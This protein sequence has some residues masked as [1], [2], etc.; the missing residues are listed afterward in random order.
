M[1]G[2]RFALVSLSACAFFLSFSA[3][4]QTSIYGGVDAT[5]YAYSSGNSGT[6][7]YDPGTGKYTADK[8][9]VGFDGGATY[10]FPSRSR[11]KA[12]IDGRGTYSPGARGGAAG[13]GALRIAFVPQ[14]NPWSPYFQIGGGVL[15]TTV[16]SNTIPNPRI[17]IN[18][19]AAVFDFGVDIRV[20]SRFAVRAIELDGMAGSNVLLSSFGAGVVYT[21]HHQ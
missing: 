10:L 7:S 2:C 5:Q 6:G 18:S 3:K 4:A 19:G 9:G 13:F 16:V 15:S 20:N 12:G 1:S 8:V 11:L 17:R 21:L 14:R